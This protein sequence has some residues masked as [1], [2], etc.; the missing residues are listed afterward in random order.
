M[1]K[2]VKN[3]QTRNAK[4]R[5]SRTEAAFWSDAPL[6]DAVLDSIFL[7]DTDG[8][9]IYV[10]EA[11]YT[12]RGYSKQELLGMKLGQLDV[13]E[14]VERNKP[15]LEEFRKTGRGVF[16]AGHFR[17]DGSIMP[18]ELHARIIASGGKS[19]ILTVARDITERKRAGEALRASEEQFRVLFE[20]AGVGVAL[21]EM[22]TGRFVKVNQR[23]CE[24]VGYSAKEMMPMSFQDITH[25]ED[26]EVNMSHLRRLISGE[27]GEYSIEKRYI[28]KNGSIIWAAI[29]VSPLSATG[30]TPRYCVGVVQDV[31]E[32]RDAERSL[33]Q[34]KELI[35][36]I[37]NNINASI[38]I[39]DART[40]SILGFNRLFLDQIGTREGDVT[41]KSFYEVLRKMS[42]TCGEKGW[43]CPLTETVSTGLQAACERVHVTEDGLEKTSEITT[44]PVKDSE[45]KM[46]QIV[47]MSQDITLRK[48]EEAARLREEELRRIWAERQVVETQLRMLQAQIEPHFLFNTLAHIM[49]LINT[50]PG[51]AKKMLG[52]LTDTLRVTLRRTREETLALGQEL[53]LIRDYLSICG[54][55]LGSRL[56]FEINVPEDLLDLPIPPLLVQPL[57][58]NA[59]K[60]G[61]EPKIEGGAV[62]ITAERAGGM[63]RVRV[64]DTGRGFCGEGDGAGVGLANV[65]KRLHGLYGKKARFAVMDNIP[66]GL[67]AV[68]EVPM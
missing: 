30:E 2:S 41:G 33:L 18:V 35:T 64:I 51:I 63:L 29:T 66:C 26:L 56:R 46:I 52:H 10:N 61:I 28:H 4:I 16:E 48:Q 67:I 47:Y 3:G 34:S 49:S 36:N 9:M 40:Y 7:H 13:P 53:E 24:I 17:K 27:I 21:V 50:D 14:Y 60:H 25:S 43:K 5:T 37:V 12:T 1:S 44:V 22:L 32:R 39:I 8:S 58:E 38:A 6:L 55:R 20:Q 62:S 59:V 57:V 11:A 45:G 31:T 23:F 42:F 68:I 65:Q 15:F 54:M 19:L